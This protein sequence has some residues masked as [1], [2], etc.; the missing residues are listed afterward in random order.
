MACRL[1]CAVKL[2]GSLLEIIHLS[3]GNIRVPID[4]L[5]VGLVDVCGML[6]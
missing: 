6:G 4:G 5:E 3:L 2:A 1:L